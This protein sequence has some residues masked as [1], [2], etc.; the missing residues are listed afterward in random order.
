MKSYNP[1]SLQP[2][3][4]VAVLFALCR[5][6]QRETGVVRAFF[7][8]LIQQATI[9]QPQT[10]KAVEQF[11]RRYHIK[12][13]RV[14][15]FEE[16]RVAFEES[17]RA[18]SEIYTLIDGLD[19]LANLLELFLDV[20]GFL[21][22]SFENLKILTTSTPARSLMRHPTFQD[23]RILI[24]N[25]NANTDLRLFISREPNSGQL[26]RLLANGNLWQEVEENIFKKADGMYV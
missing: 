2:D 11:Y 25:S 13:Q 1:A 8:L 22:R 6:G 16:V 14:P 5:Y 23:G 21:I 18:F 24:K 4:P 3:H 19:E 12:H 10:P 7:L 20:L 17:L 26:R 9:L 15:T